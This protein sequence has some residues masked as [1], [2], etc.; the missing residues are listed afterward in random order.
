M[1]AWPS[2]LSRFA[3]RF[4]PLALVLMALPVSAQEAQP[5]AAYTKHVSEGLSEF[6]LSHFEEA[7]EQFKQA[8][9][10]YPN[11]RTLRGLGMVEFELRHYSASVDL[12]Q[13]ALASSVKPLADKLRSDTEALLERARS[14]IGEVRLVIE[15]AST[16]ITVD[17]VSAADAGS[18]PLVLDVGDHVIELRATG[19]LAQTHRVQV[20]GGAEQTLRVKLAA[21]SAE[22]AEAEARPDREPTKP[23]P[24]RRRW[25]LWTTIGVVVAGGA[26]AA[27]VLLTRDP[28]PEPQ[29]L[30]T[31]NTPPSSAFYALERGR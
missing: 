29:P 26:V 14:Y 15:P 11:A 18:E 28:D 27:A 8:H 4:A 22:V 30:T 24:L 23:V 21:F 2:R 17:G 16:S 10:L 5:P 7:R 20:E 6:E 31:D 3:L 1:L 19:Y 25:W 9:A 13:Q 12:L